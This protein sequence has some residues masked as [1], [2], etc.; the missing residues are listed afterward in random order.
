MTT[1]A[2][3]GAHILI[4]DDNP[5][6]RDALAAYLR[7]Q[8]LRA[9]TV[10]SA[11]DARLALASGQYSL[12]VLDVMMPG[13]GGLS[14]CRA[15]AANGRLP[16]ILLT[17]M[18]TPADKLAGFD[19]GAD[20]YVVKPFDPPELL[21][22]I[23][24][25]LRRCTA[26]ANPHPYFTAPAPLAMPAVASA[27]PYAGFAFDAWYLDVQKRELYDQNRLQ[28][29]PLSQVEYRLLRV[30]V[31]HPGTVLSRDRLM[32]LTVGDEALPFDRSIDSQVSRL[33][34][35]LER[36]PRQPDLLKTVWGQGY[37]FATEVVACA[38]DARRAMHLP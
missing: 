30:L 22:R 12:L 18:K 31:D 3:T 4:V 35:K 21:A 33:R 1:A 6:I 10:A 16:V 28:P 13:E 11:E 34:K 38:L 36:D 26:N 17:G 19:S 7:R 25:V 27:N 14:L 8:G 24:S 37:L 9:S 5:D 2:H 15:V 29:V 23:R 20:D 32:D